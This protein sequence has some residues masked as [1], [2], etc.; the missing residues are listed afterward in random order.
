MKMRIFLQ[1][2]MN[3]LLKTQ[4]KKMSYLLKTQQKK[5][6]CLLK[7]PS[8]E[9]TRLSTIHYDLPIKLFQKK[10]LLSMKLEYRKALFVLLKKLITSIM[11]KNPETFTYCIQLIS[12]MVQFIFQQILKT[13]LVKTMNHTTTHCHELLNLIFKHNFE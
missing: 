7:T 4:Q 5:V 8:K 10:T 13:F 6:D 11:E 1:K 2:K 12:K 3:Y 9:I